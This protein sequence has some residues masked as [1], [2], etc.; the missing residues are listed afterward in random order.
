MLQYLE[1]HLKEQ[2]INILERVPL[3]GMVMFQLR[4]RQGWSRSVLPIGKYERD[5]K[6]NR[7][8]ALGRIDIHSSCEVRFGLNFAW[9]KSF[10]PKRCV[11][12]PSVRFVSVGNN[13]LSNCGCE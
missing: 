12:A 2:E 3:G 13:A 5:K 9:F 4:S 10:A 11:S 8:N 1:I 6:E 7:D